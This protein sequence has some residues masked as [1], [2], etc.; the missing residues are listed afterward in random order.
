MTMSIANVLGSCDQLPRLL[1]L[2]QH[3]GSYLLSPEFST[4]T[5]QF[6][7][8]LS[9]GDTCSD[10]L[11]VDEAALTESHCVLQRALRQFQ[12]MMTVR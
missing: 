2:L 10:L 4:N 7:T 11:P 6:S 5:E 1:F 9:E 12:D 8:A 3:A